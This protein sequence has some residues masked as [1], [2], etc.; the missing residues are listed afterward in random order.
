MDNHQTYKSTILNIINQ[1]FDEA[2]GRIDDIC[3]KNFYSFS[4]VFNRHWRNKKDIP[5]DLL[6]IPRSLY[7]L[8]IGKIFKKIVKP[9]PRSGKVKELEKIIYQ[10]LVDLSGLERKIEKHVEAH[11]L[12]FERDFVEILEHIPALQRDQF[13]RELEIQ[14]ERLKTPIEGMREAI[15]FLAA[16]IV[17]K[18]F[19]DKVVFGSMLG[20]GQAVATSIYLDQLSWFG[21]LWASIFGVPAWVSTVGAA[22]GAM[23][24]IIIASL[25]SPFLEVGINRLRAKKIL[26]QVVSNAKEKLTKSGPDA[27]DVAGKI[28]IYLQTLPEL[29]YLAK[30]IANR[31]VKA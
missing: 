10:D 24:G 3:E 20:T 13:V 19:S 7:N 8:T 14:L 4:A 2:Y 9:F 28:A 21:S 1:H 15:M 30:K 11:K 17:G 26:Q 16:G 22:S 25:L 18:V 12:R 23:I 31:I 5:S 27:F 6:V 29:I